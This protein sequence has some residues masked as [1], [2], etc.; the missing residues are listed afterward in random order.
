MFPRLHAIIIK[1][2][3]HLRKPPIRDSFNHCKHTTSSIDPKWQLCSLKWDKLIKNQQ[4]NIHLTK[5]PAKRWNAPMIRLGSC[6]RML[7]VKLNLLSMSDLFF[8]LFVCFNKE[9]LWQTLKNKNKRYLKVLND[10]SMNRASF[11][12]W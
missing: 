12:N 9:R 10:L 4:R 6:I 8:S 3:E 1:F 5:G 7:Q 2:K 11:L